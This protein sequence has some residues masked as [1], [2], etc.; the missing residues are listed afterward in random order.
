MAA[1][2]IVNKS[3]GYKATT[4]TDAT[5]VTT[6]RV[7]LLSIQILGSASGETVIVTDTEGNQILKDT[8]TVADTTYETSFYG[9]PVD[10]LKV[11]LSAATAYAIFLVE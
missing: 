2:T 7:K 11:T 10:G 1:A 4:G 5:A 8:C 9:Q 6:D 3:W